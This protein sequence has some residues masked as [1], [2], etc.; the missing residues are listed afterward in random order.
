MVGHARRPLLDDS[1]KCVILCHPPRKEYYEKFVYEALPVESHRQHFLHNH[2]NTELVAGSRELSKVSKLWWT[3]L[4][5][6][7][8]TMVFK[9]S[10]RHLSDHLSE[11]L[12]NTLSDLES[13]KCVS[14]EEDMC[15]SPS[16]LGRIASFYHIGYTTIEWFSSSLTSKTKMEGLLGILASASEYAELLIR[17]GEEELIRKLINHQRFAFENLKC[18][19][20]HEK[21]NVLLQA[22]F[23]RHTVV[24]NLAVDQQ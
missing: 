11:L 21:A 1:G 12:E 16:N 13:S 22:H 6:H 9:V 4:H 2:L 3:I 7:L 15:L 23:S 18:N 14:I 24:G 19:D 8:C 17:P 10:V 5:G 20:P